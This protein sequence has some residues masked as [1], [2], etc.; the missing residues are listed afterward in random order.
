RS[1]DAILAAVIRG[2]APLQLRE[3]FEEAIEAIQFVQREDFENFEGDTTKFEK[4]RPMLDNC[5]QFQLNQEEKE[6]RIFSPFNVLAGVLGLVLLV[7]GFI[8]IRDYWRW[9]NYLNR[10]KT[11]QGIVVVESDLGWWKDSISGLRDPSAINPV[12]ILGEYGLQTKNVESDWR[13]FQDLSPQMILQR[14]NKVLQTPEGVKLSFE[15][16]ILTANGNVASNW[17]NEAKKLSTA[18]GGVNEFRLGDEALKTKIESNSVLF[19]CGT[20]DISDGQ[21]VKISEII[22]D[23][24]LLAD[25]GKNWQI[26]VRGHADSS[27]TMDVNSQI[28]Q[29]RAEKIVQELVKSDKLKTLVQSFK[30]IG[31][32][33]SEKSD[34]KVDFKVNLAK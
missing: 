25:S 16:G 12:E 9:S 8:Y 17:L 27:G 34:C 24:E 15:N 29:Q 22:K 23:V 20:V 7:F 1:P 33:V 32:G 13:A 18:I 11:E 4:S 26:E 28:S 5:L 30:T 2:N 6:S 31:I 21:S 10:L 14:A 19:N 3:I